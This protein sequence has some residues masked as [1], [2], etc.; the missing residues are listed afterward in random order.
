MCKGCLKAVCEE[1]PPPQSW[2]FCST[3]PSI[4]SSLPK[5]KRAIC[6]THNLL[7]QIQKHPPSGHTKL[8]VTP[9]LINLNL[10]FEG[11]AG[12][13]HAYSS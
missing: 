2:P 10:H 4:A 6:F 9:D 11:S 1:M 12:G 3:G 13:F 8:I 5:L 7:F